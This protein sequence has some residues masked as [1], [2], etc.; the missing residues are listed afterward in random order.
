MFRG[1]KG[2]MRERGIPEAVKK[3]LRPAIKKRFMMPDYCDGCELPMG[4]E[5]RSRVI[6]FEPSD[7]VE[8]PYVASYFI[9]HKTCFD[10]GIPVVKRR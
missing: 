8:N 6:M 2:K 7:S 10:S 4:N 9:E 3:I 1:L 5:I